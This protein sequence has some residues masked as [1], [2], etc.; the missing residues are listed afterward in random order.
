MKWCIEKEV[1]GVITDDP[2]LFL[3]VCGEVGEGETKGKG[4]EIGLMDY[5]SV[6]GIYILVLVLGTIFR[7]RFLSGGEKVKRKG[8]IAL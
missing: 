4:M 6:I 5:L 1:D 2:K 8:K 3:E 7:Y